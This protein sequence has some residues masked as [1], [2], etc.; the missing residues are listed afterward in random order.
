M[1]VT[2]THQWLVVIIHDPLIGHIKVHWILHPT[3][4]S[5]TPD[6]GRYI[7]PMAFRFAIGGSR[8]DLRGETQ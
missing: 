6:W 7:L 5:N 3:W 1:G 2:D 4:L 8:R